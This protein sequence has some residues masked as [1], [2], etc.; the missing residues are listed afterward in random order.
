[1]ASSLQEKFNDQEDTLAFLW[2]ESPSLGCLSLLVRWESR[3]IYSNHSNKKNLRSPKQA[4]P[5]GIDHQQ[6]L[7]IIVI[8]LSICAEEATVA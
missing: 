6:I 1:V 8:P 4:R 3:E 5:G 7:Q 2:S